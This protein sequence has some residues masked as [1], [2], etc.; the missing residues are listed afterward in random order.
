MPDELISRR[1]AVR[2]SGLGILAL[3]GGACL[4]SAG[5]GSGTRVPG[6]DGRLAS[7]PHAPFGSVDPGLQALRI[8]GARDG[9]L[10]VPASY[11]ADAPA[12]LVLLLHGAGQSAG[13]LV[14]RIRP[15]AD[16]L[17]LVLLAPDSRARTWETSYGV[18]GPDTFFVD[19]ALARTFETVAVDARRVSVAGFSDGAS[20]AL[21]LGLVNGD[22]FGRIAAFSPGYIAAGARRGRPRI[23]ITHGTADTVLAIDRTSRRFVP[24]LR[25]QGYHVEYHEFNGGHVL[26]PSLLREGVAWLSGA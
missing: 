2:R 10:F 16:E 15:L 23:F 8:G 5:A 1:A 6:L 18:Y 13:G 7:R 17:G 20:Y 14:E 26:P 3:A 21:S 11:R 4:P 9:L 19:L 22:L 24:A 12:S 25:E